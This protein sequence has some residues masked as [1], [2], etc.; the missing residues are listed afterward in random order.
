MSIYIF[1]KIRYAEEGCL[2]GYPFFYI[3]NKKGEMPS[4]IPQALDS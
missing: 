4:E 1:S 3:L 2:E